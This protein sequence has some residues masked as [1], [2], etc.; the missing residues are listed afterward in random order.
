MSQSSDKIRGESPSTQQIH[1]GLG[2]IINNCHSL[3][4]VS[5]NWSINQ[6]KCYVQSC[7]EQ[8]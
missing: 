8:D 5:G 7:Y 1:C 3:S 6:I 4:D 2:L